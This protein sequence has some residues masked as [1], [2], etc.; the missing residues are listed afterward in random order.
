MVARADRT[1]RTAEAAGER[2]LL[3]LDNVTMRFGGV[4]ALDEAKLSTCR[5]ARSS[6]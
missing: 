6:R 5:R 1:S 4:M 2:V 3:E